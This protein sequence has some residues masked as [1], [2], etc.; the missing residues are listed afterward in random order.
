VLAEKA[1]Y[2]IPKPSE[3]T[4]ADTDDRNMSRRDSSRSIPAT[5]ENMAFSVEADFIASSSTDYIPPSQLDLQLD[6]SEAVPVE[7]T[8]FEIKDGI[9]I[10]DV[11]IT[12]S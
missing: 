1:R 4:H 12:H 2:F 10:P 9:I 6:S 5:D 11:S 7:V 3:P 8:R